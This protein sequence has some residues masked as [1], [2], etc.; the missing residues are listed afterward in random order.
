MFGLLE[1]FDI[2]NA[3]HNFESTDLCSACS[4]LLKALKYS[5]V[6]KTDFDDESI[7]KFIYFSAPNRVYFNFQERL[8]LSQI[9][10]MKFVC[11]ISQNELI[12]TGYNEKNLT[13]LAVELVCSKYDR[14]ESSYYITQVLNKLFNDYV[15]IIFKHQDN[16]EF[17][18]YVDGLVCMSD[19]FKTSK[20]TYNQIH[21]I[22]KI[23]PA[24]IIGVNNIKEYYEEISFAFSREYIKRPESYEYMV[25]E[26]FP[27]ITD[28][29]IE[30]TVSKTAINEFAQKSKHYYFEIYGDDYVIIDESF[31]VM[32]DN[33]EDWTLIE[34]NNFI[35]KEAQEEFN[36]EY[37]NDDSLDLDYSKIDENILSDPVKLL[38]LV[39]AWDKERENNERI[40]RI[41]Y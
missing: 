12:G 21:T 26:C 23:S 13:I 32:E 33:D 36:I 1:V 15:F 22:L 2:E 34:L 37:F 41:D 17:C 30:E 9:G 8:Y 5:F 10:T 35:P 4:S 20:L 16:I 31:I 39:E 29:I 24:Y 6:A 40:D 25:Y 3:L 11:E 19:W 14:S 38:E 27:T 7:E 18:S 28:D